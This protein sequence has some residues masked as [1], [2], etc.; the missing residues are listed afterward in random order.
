MDEKYNEATH[1]RA[2]GQ[3]TMDAPLVT[4]DLRFFITQIK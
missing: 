3:R 4:I 2:Q 1:N